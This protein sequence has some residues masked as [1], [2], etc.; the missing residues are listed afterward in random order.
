MLLYED[1]AVPI[2]NNF[3][4]DHTYQIYSFN[5]MFIKFEQ[6]KSKFKKKIILFN[7]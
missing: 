5:L 4:D 6:F 7:F 3:M 1:I 2:N